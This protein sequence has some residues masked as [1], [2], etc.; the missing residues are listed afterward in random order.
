[1][2][3]EQININGESYT[4]TAAMPALPTGTRNVVVVDRGWIFAGDVT[5]RLGCRPLI[6]G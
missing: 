3:R 6:A 2:T 5:G 1:M 4:K